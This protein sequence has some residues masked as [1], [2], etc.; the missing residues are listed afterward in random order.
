MAKKDSEIEKL[1]YLRRVQQAQA[2]AYHELPAGLEPWQIIPG[3]TFAGS[4][5][6][7]GIY[8]TALPGKDGNGAGFSNI[9]S[10]RV[11]PDINEPEYTKDQEIDERKNKADAIAKILKAMDGS[12][13]SGSLGINTAQDP[14]AKAAAD[15]RRIEQAERIYRSVYS[16]QKQKKPKKDYGFIPNVLGADSLTSGTR[17]NWFHSPNAKK[18]MAK[19]EMNDA[20]VG[21]AVSVLDKKL[22]GKNPEFVKKVLAH[23]H[24]MVA[25]AY[26]GMKSDVPGKKASKKGAPEKKLRPKPKEGAS[27]EL[28]SRHDDVD[29]WGSN[30][31]L[32]K[33]GEGGTLQTLKD[34][35]HMAD[36]PRPKPTPEQIAER[37]TQEDRKAQMLDMKRRNRDAA[38]GRMMEALR[39]LLPG[40]EE[41]P[42]E[43]QQ[44]QQRPAPG[45]SDPR[46]GPARLA[47]L[48]GYGTY[49]V[50]TPIENS[51]YTPPGPP[52][53]ETGNVPQFQQPQVR[54]PPMGPQR[55]SALPMHGGQTVPQGPSQSLVDPTAAAMAEQVDPAEG[56]SKL[57]QVV[58]T[59]N[60]L[61]NRSGAQGIDMDGVSDR[62]MDLYQSLAETLGTDV[63]RKQ[64]ETIMQ[65]S[66]LQGGPQPMSAL[67]LMR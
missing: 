67:S 11:V 66:G 59:A 27:Q 21:N 50:P 39:R 60:A 31:P 47:N 63:A 52:R 30:L 22:K 34:I 6:E 56:V 45:N 35:Y 13:G 55:L 4:S 57:E 25:E 15:K 23:Q 36:L 51:P 40:A 5:R 7:T 12:D 54:T 10:R 44:A 37:K 3:E 8:R 58:A 14:K 48:P 26:L 24:P 38:P 64:F 9:G 53:I 33:G 2:N 43:P 61:L 18:P 32:P 49:P 29:L 42:G 65:K 28:N 20:F 19:G 62:L 1:K 17:A 16:E 46:Q 41:G